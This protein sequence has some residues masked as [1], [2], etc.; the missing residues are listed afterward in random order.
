MDIYA[1]LKK[2]GIRFNTEG[3]IHKDDIG[4]VEKVLTGK[5]ILGYPLL[6]SGTDFPLKKILDNE[7]SNKEMYQELI[8]KSK[9]KEI[10]KLPP[11]GQLFHLG[12][13][14]FLADNDSKEIVYY[15]Q[16]TLQHFKSIL[17]V[18][19]IAVWLKYV[20]DYMDLPTGERVSKYVFFNILLPLADAIMTDAMQ[21][22]DGF[23]FWL[24]R[25]REAISKHMY[26][27][28]VMRDA[29]TVTRITST[30]QLNEIAPSIWGHEA[31]KENRKLL[32]SKKELF[33]E[34]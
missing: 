22:S 32:I 31:A 30:N 23:R 18:T 11:N 1:K 4:K 21:T 9:K 8:G 16:Y 33:P 14:L 17:T 15:V 10:L 12:H 13:K 27:Y 3:Q 20:S 19:Q 25:T 26:V 6:I 24:N 28:A 29:D 2:A 34:D 5:M 7:E